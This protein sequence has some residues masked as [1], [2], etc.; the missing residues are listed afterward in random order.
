MFG[1]NDNMT[2]IYAKHAE[3]KDDQLNVLFVVYPDI[4]LLDLVGPL[5]VF[6]HARRHESVAPAYSTHVVS[7]HGGQIATNTI[8]EIG[9]AALTDWTSAAAR[10]PIH[11]LVVVGGD[12]AI[13]AAQDQPFVAQVRV[14]ADRSARVCSVCSGALVLA[15]AGLLDGRR[16][17][18]HWEDCDRLARQFPAVNVEVDPIFVKDGTVWTSAGITAG[19]DMALAMIAEDL[20][21]PAAIAMARSLVT[22]MVRSGGQSQFSAELDRQSR[23]T[24]GRF[25]ALHAWISD[26]IQMTI[27]VEDMADQTG[28]SARNFSR[29]YS[30]LMGTS[31]AKGVEVLRVDRGRDLLM[32]TDKSIKEIAA[33]CGFQ[34]DERMRRAFMRTIHTSPSEYRK[35]F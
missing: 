4:V 27:T 11:T 5:Q 2:S 14:L 17:V 22:P 7:A 25:S 18:T 35:Q 28:M 13:E 32:T 12:G 29:R 16:A 1:M 15:A 19:I 34:D 10:N 3:T 33:L 23:D 9:S 26:N 31:P 20:G 21:K 8:V 24:A 30:K 6:T